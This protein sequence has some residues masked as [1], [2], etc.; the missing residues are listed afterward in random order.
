MSELGL[1]Q[2]AAFFAAATTACCALAAN[3]SPS[4]TNAVAKPIT[5]SV[6]PTL[7]PVD[8]GVADVDPL[9]TTGRV[10]PTDLRQPA[11]FDRVYEV[12]LDG[13]R[14]F[15]RAHGGVYAVFPRS[16]YVQTRGGVVPIVPAGTV[17]HLG[18]LPKTEFDPAHQDEATLNPANAKPARP[19]RR[20]D[21]APSN[22]APMPESA[23]AR[24]APAARSKPALRQ[25]T[26]PPLS[27]AAPPVAKGPEGS[28][29]WSSD[30]LRVSRTGE[31]LD[32][33]RAARLSEKTTTPRAGLLAE[34][35][36]DQ[37]A[38]ASEPAR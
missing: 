25:N 13:K 36:A 31:L 1:K 3:S 11:N 19:A 6:Q 15:V 27:D 37:Q 17:Y 9:G 23:A 22:A 8:P 16:D 34:P 7:R 4:P 38:A 30:M 35:A 10:L 2:A 12:E 26:D 29:I 5:K 33:A 24:P 28:S 20:D 14:F 18:S 32:K 21:S